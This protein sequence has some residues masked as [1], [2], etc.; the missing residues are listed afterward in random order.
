MKTVCCQCGKKLIGRTDKKFC[1]ADCKNSYHNDYRKKRSP[2]MT[3][4]PQLPV[5]GKH[6]FE[7]KKT[8]SNRCEQM[9]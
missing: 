4:E 6:G 8:K 9:S 7:N 3:R 2:S 5:Y 1:D